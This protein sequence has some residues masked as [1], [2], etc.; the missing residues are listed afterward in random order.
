MRN[1]IFFEIQT[2]K[3][4]KNKMKKIE[5]NMNQSISRDKLCFCTLKLY[6]KSCINY[7]V[8]ELFH[9]DIIQPSIFPHQLIILPLK[10][11]Q[12]K[13]IHFTIWCDISHLVITPCTIKWQVSCVTTLIVILWHACIVKCPVCHWWLSIHLH[14]VNLL[15][16]RLNLLW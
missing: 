15:L 6:N 11:L 3:N 9:N 16:K 1:I 4:E 8:F 5:N 2:K 10:L 14:S 12:I 13:Q 7:R